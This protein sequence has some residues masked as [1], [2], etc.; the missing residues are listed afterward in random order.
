MKT[1][2]IPVMETL[3]VVDIV[4]PEMKSEEVLLKIKYVGFA[5]PT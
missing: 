4:K 5:A 1:I 2:Q 3:Q